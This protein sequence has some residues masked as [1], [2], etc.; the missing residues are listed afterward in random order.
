M[1]RGEW[2][3][4]ADYVENL[5]DEL[6]HNQDADKASAGQWWHPARYVDWDRMAR[7]LEMSGD[8]ETIRGPS[9]VFV[10]DNQ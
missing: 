7:D 9:G 2:D 6:G 4:L 10:F 5:W 3:T 1:F 8:V